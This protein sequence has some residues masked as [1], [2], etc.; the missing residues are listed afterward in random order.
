MNFK[1]HQENERITPVLANS[2]WL[3][4]LFRI[5]FKILLLT[6]KALNGRAPNYVTDLLTPI[7]PERSRKS[8]DV[9]LLARD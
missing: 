8:V 7:V 9:A 2:H 1:W 3:S 6:L 5:N 4:V